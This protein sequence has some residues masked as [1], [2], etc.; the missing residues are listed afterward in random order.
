[1][2]FKP[3]A[4]SLFLAALAVPALSAAQVTP[5]IEYDWTR[6]LS[7]NAFAGA[8]L[9]GS[10]AGVST[11]AAVG[12]GVARRW[13]IEASASWIDR[14]P[15]SEAYAA[16]ISA[17]VHVGVRRPALPFLKAGVGMYSATFDTARYEA[18]EFYRR[19]IGETGGLTGTR[20]TFRDPSIVVG[21]GV[22][23]LVARHV[24]LRPAVETAI[25]IRDGHRYTVTTAA[26][27]VAYHFEQHE[28]TP[29]RRR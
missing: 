29:W 1:M 15:G 21:G 23:V 24:G 26:F 16:S 17:Q 28:I 11:G 13:V 12:W 9:D 5:T 2:T 20:R 10:D 14:A 3:V 18:P 25:V 6:R 7:I 27:H 4:L 22:N 19:R 8:A